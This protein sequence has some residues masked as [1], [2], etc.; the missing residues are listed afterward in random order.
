[1]KDSLCVCVSLR[2]EHQG[3]SI[4]HS[5]GLDSGSAH[6][7]AEI[8]STE[9]GHHSASFAPAAASASSASLLAR[10][11]L[12]VLPRSDRSVM[13]PRSLPSLMQAPDLQ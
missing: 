9:V 13:C 2:T 11:R 3:M 1:M 12:L 10:G 5:G 4:A 8:M 6:C 7:T